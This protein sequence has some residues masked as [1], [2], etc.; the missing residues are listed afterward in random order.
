MAYREVRKSREVVELWADLGVEEMDDFSSG[1]DIS[2]GCRGCEQQFLLHIIKFF[3][4]QH[5]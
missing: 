1:D 3:T 2:G 4:E 5:C